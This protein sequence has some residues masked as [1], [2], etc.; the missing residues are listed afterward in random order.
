MDEEVKF[1]Q[2]KTE[3]RNQRMKR[4][5]KVASLDLS[6][7]K[8]KVVAKR[9]TYK[10]S[11]HFD[12]LD[13]LGIGTY[14]F[15]KHAVEKKSGRHVAVKI[16]RRKTAREMLRN[17]YNILKSID[18]EHVVKVYDFI[19]NDAND[20]SYLVMEYYEGKDLSKWAEE[21]KQFS[22]EEIKKVM[23]QVIQWVK[24]LHEQGVA[25]RDIKPENVLV[26]EHNEVKLIDFNISKTTLG[27][28][29]CSDDSSG[30]FKSTFY[31]Q[32]SSPLYAAPELKNSC[33]YSESVDIWGLGIVMFTLAMGTFKSHS[34]NSI[35]CCS[36]RVQLIHEAINTQID[37]ED[38]A[39]TLLLSLLS[40]KAEDRPSAEE[41][42]NSSW[43]A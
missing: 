35:L 43:L 29:S 4:F 40:E 34:F 20:E 1:G 38:E 36:E 7:M 33:G 37:L 15:V 13:N 5:R 18:N 21:H 11:D 28:A 30:K 8:Q 17:E 26:N 25:H 16:C 9:P 12:S 24:D 22:Q 10:L 23:N 41:C 6:I 19:D 3:E 14:S 39:K 42:L 27:S 31:T 32:V 2:D